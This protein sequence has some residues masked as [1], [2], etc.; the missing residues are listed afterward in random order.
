MRTIK[1]LLITA[2]LLLLSISVKGQIVGSTLQ[3]PFQL[4]TKSGSF[5]YT[6]SRLVLSRYGDTY[7]VVGPEVFMEITLSVPMDIEIIHDDLGVHDSYLHILNSEGFEIAYNEN[8][9]GLMAYI[10]TDLSAGKYYIVSEGNGRSGYLGVTIKGQPIVYSQDF[11]YSVQPTITSVESGT[12]GSLGGSFNVSSLGGATYTIPIE[13]PLGFGSLKPQLSIVYNSQSGNG[14]CGYGTNISGLSSITR[15][16]KDIYHDNITK[17]VDFLAN[18]A[19]YLDGVRL[20]CIEGTEGQE[21][22]K[23][24]P[25]SDPY[26]IVKTHVDYT[27]TSNY[28]WFEV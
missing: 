15:G 3:N 16:P 10:N 9:N 27:S 6:S 1:T 12:V 8:Y 19:L 25:E 4:G 28:I 11:G 5:T 24:N 7:G 23:Y 17:G 22:A 21:G 13:V 14:M 26:T 2:L 18:D 20:I